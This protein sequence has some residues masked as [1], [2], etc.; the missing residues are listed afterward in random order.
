[1]CSLSAYPRILFEK[2]DLFVDDDEAS[3]PDSFDCVDEN[4]FRPPFK[5]RH[6]LEGKMIKIVLKGL[7]HGMNIRDFSMNNFPD[8]VKSV[9]GFITRVGKDLPRH[10]TINI[11]PLTSRI[12]FKK[13]QLEVDDNEATPPEP[14]DLA[15]QYDDREYS[16]HGTNQ[17]Q[18]GVR[19]GNFSDG[20]PE[21]GKHKETSEESVEV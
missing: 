1:M 21:V 17:A 5:K 19:L 11:S 14:F 3:L 15:E 2:C 20:V 10:I 4:S 13:S 12:M 18:E 16:G 9:L 6:G 8:V 7:P